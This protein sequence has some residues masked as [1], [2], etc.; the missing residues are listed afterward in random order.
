[1]PI[2]RSQRS[3]GVEAQAHFAHYQRVGEG[4]R[5]A[6]GIFHDVHFLWGEE[7]DSSHSPLTVWEVSQFLVSTGGNKIG[8][9]TLNDKIDV[10]F[11][12]GNKGAFHKDFDAYLPMMSPSG[13]VFMH[14]VNDEG[15]HGPRAAFERCK[16]MGFRCEEFISLVDTELALKREADGIPSESPHEAWLRHWRGRSCGVG[17]IWMWPKG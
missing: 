16:R 12:D 8:S 14:D 6:A 17:A 5:V 11:I 9:A 3:G 2:V 15:K 1:M 13:V 10:L 7:G 4:T